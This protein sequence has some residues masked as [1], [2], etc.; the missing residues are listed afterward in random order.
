MH[1]KVDRDVCVA[2]GQCSLCA[3]TVFGQD[4]DGDG[5]VVLLDPDPPPELNDAVREAVRFCPSGAIE[6][7]G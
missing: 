2:H 7:T 5:R 1:V 4:D 6:V 3:P